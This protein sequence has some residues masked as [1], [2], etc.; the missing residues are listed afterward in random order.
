M[1]LLVLEETVR[2]VTV[3]ELRIFEEGYCMVGVTIYSF[4]Y[5]NRSHLPQ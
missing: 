1:V 3:F 5:R 4:I 2:S